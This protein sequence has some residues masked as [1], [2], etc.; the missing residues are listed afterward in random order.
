[1]PFYMREAIHMMQ[2]KIARII[3]GDP[4]EPDHWLDIEGYARLVSR[5]L[6]SEN[7]GST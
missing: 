1:M 3:S 5:E 6:E 4:F 7:V 2:H